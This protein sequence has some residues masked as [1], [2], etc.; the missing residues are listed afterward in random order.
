MLRLLLALLLTG[1]LFAQPGTALRALR[2]KISAGDLPSAESILEVHRAEKGEDEEYQQGLAWLA[3]GAFLTG[4]LTRA[5]QYARQA[6]ALAQQHPESPAAN[7]LLGTGI[8]VEAQC[9]AARGKQKAAIQYLDQAL[10][11]HQNAPTALRSRIWKR[12]NQFALTGTKAL[13]YQPEDRL[14]PE[15]KSTGRAQVLFLFAEWCGD[16]KA[17]ALALRK[18]V[19]KFSGRPVDFRALTRF[20]DADH[21]TEKARV[22]KVWKEAYPGLS[23]MPIEFSEDAMVR[24]GGSATPTFVLVDRKGLVQLYSPTR[25]TAERLSSE[26]ERILR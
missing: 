26:I 11:T 4:D 10:A 8:E 22:E 5:Q 18:A 25:L 16:C 13:S 3:R 19:E 2:L 20:Y 15:M 9:L 7:Y 6:L 21:V 14:G 23:E 1:S 17:Q 24:Y 12:R